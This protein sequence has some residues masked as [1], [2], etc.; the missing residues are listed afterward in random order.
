MDRCD[1]SNGILNVLISIAADGFRSGRV[2]FNRAREVLATEG[3]SC[4]YMNAKVVNI[5]P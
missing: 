2:K 5:I 4:G 1:N 3:D